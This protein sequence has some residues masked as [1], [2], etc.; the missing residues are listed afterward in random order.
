MLGDDLLGLRQASP[1]VLGLHGA[2]SSVNAH[3]SNLLLS[4]V[5]SGAVTPEQRADIEKSGIREALRMEQGIRAVPPSGFRPL[6]GFDVHPAVRSLLLFPYLDVDGR[7]TDHFQVKIFPPPDAATGRPKYLQPKR[8]G[9]H[10]YLV[11][12]ALG[13][14]LEPGRELWITEGAKKT[15]A[16]ASLGLAAVGLSG[17]Q[18]WRERGSRRLLPDFDRLPLAGRAVR[19]VPDGD[20]RTNPA[21]ER[22]AADLAEALEG[23]GARARIVL[24]PIGTKLDDLVAA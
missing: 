23:R 8:S 15:C 22:G 12:R 21:V 13:A 5:Y 2:G 6:L 18:N 7:W 4:P 19:L 17:I 3:L 10:L 24:L 20:V 16:A 14:V 1:V 11:R 9:S